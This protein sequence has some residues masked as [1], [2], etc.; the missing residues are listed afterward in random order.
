MTNKKRKRFHKIFTRSLADK[1]TKLIVCEI[2]AQYSTAFQNNSQNR[3]VS[4]LLCCGMK[5]HISWN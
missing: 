5:A 1:C 3:S 2:H 4:S